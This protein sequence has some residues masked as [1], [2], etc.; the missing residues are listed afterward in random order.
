RG[1]A[2]AEAARFNM[3]CDGA[4]VC[5]TCLDGRVEVAQGGHS[6]VLQQTEQVSYTENGFGPAASIDPVMVA[7]WQA[8]NLYFRNET[9][10]SVVDE[11]N[12]YRPGRIVLMNR[13][14]GQRRVTAHFKLD[15][16]EVIITQLRESFGARVTALPAGIVLIS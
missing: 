8:G 15:R 3:R 10:S 6:M 12:R 4:A 1:R 5:V 14:L 16:L 7:G 9:L 2:R 13:A 11:V